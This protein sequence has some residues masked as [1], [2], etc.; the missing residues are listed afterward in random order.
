MTAK[1]K[2]VVG[3]IAAAGFL[4]SCSTS[5]NN[6][7]AVDSGSSGDDS[8]GMT[9]DSGTA[10]DGAMSCPA[11]V[12]PATTTDCPV[13]VAE[14]NCDKNLRPFVFV[15]GTFGS[16]DNFEHVAQLMTS[17]GYCADH[18]VSVEY[19]SVNGVFAGAC[20]GMLNTDP[21]IDAVIDRVLANTTDCSGH[22]FTQV[23]LAGHSQGTAH[24]GTYLQT[25]AQ[26]AK[27]AHYI[28]FS[29]VPAVVVPTLSLSSMHDLGNSPHHVTGGTLC[30]SGPGEAPVP[31]GCNVVEVTFKDQDHFA[32][33]ASKDSF[34]AVYKYLTGKAPKYTDIQCGEDPV[35]IV[36]VSETFAD[37]TPVSGKVEVRPV[38]DTPRAAD[39]P[40]AT[41]MPGMDGR[42]GPISLKRNVPYEFKGFDSQGN[43]VGYSYFT[44]FKRSNHLVSLLTPSNCSNV[45]AAS[46]D[47]VV[48]GPNHTAVVARW[49]GG[50]FR[51]DLGAS[52]K[53]DG[54][55]HPGPFEVLTDGNAGASA[56]ATQALGG[57]V[58]G[59]FMYDANQPDGGPPNMTTD[60]G[61]P[62]SYNF[63]AFTDVYM[64]ATTP[65]FITFTLTAG[66][67]DPTAMNVPLKI[68]NW[69]SSDALIS[70]FFQ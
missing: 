20:P 21:L 18:I 40:V 22:A 61:L 63:I 66:S 64:Q 68:S 36:G 26:A 9:P 35:S 3:L 49:G 46:T 6:K 5:N 15:H 57:G 13:V 50:G 60:L 33:A 4:C 38:G 10:S 39:T 54:T 19:D 45:K 30:T 69:P 52:L 41:I 55:E 70:I 65:G 2:V 44:G 14:S 27:V 47:H 7:P 59:F 17:N 48:R 1:N 56:L 8:G 28:N 31:D 23:D 37:N 32:V 16:G 29:G 58:V 67:E 43:F 42:F 34:V 53:V 11:P 62:Y 51:Q 24:C 25:P 12:T